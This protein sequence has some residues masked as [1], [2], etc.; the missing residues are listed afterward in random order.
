MASRRLFRSELE[1]DASRPLLFFIGILVVL[2][3]IA[4]GAVVGFEYRDFL[5]R[6]HEK[7]K[8]LIR[9]PVVQNPP[10]P[11]I[12]CEDPIRSREEVSRICRARFRATQIGSK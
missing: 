10:P 4:T 7:N 6:Q 9:R 5:A 2:S 8:P 12:R 3:A 11:L 1:S